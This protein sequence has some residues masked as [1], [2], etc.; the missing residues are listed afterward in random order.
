MTG[1]VK[2]KGL[3]EFQRACNKGGKEAKQGLNRRLVAAGQGV[4]EEARSRIS[5]YSAKSAAGIRP[6]ARVGTVVVEQRLRRT[7]GL[8]PEFGRLQMRRGLVPALEAKRPELE[9]QLE[10]MLADLVNGF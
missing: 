3:R 5:R 2:V 9:R 6:R 10:R 7:T 1:S 8:R 4:A